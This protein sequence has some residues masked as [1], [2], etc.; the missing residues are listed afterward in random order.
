MPYDYVQKCQWA[1]WLFDNYPL[2]PEAKQF[3]HEEAAFT[4]LHRAAPEL[5]KLLVLGEHLWEKKV[6]PILAS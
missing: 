2:A 5:V 3:F 4:E 1:C 6:R